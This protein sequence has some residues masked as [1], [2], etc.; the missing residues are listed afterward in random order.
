LLET[1]DDWI[2]HRQQQRQRSG[3]K[4]QESVRPYLGLYLST[5]SDRSRLPPSGL[6]S[7]PPIKKHKTT[8]R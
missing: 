8:H 1:V 6:P 4:R 3:R 5:E 2:A 7:R